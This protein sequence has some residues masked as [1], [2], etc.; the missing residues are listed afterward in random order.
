[1][2]IQPSGCHVQKLCVCYKNLHTSW[3]CFTVHI[4][5]HSIHTWRSASKSGLDI[6][7]NWHSA[8]QSK[9]YHYDLFRGDH[10]KAFITG[11]SYCIDQIQSFKNT[12]NIF[13]DIL[14]WLFNCWEFCCIDLLCG[15]FW[16][17]MIQM[18]KWLQVLLFYLL[19]N[20]QWKSVRIYIA[21]KSRKIIGA[22]MF[23]RMSLSWFNAA[24]CRV[25][26]SCHSLQGST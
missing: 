20:R 23:N 18:E 21:P 10:Y 8:F 25:N 19:L 3:V 6:C 4:E 22:H 15:S 11:E 1:M 13:F 24:I 12:F 17:N 5:L 14:Q 26:M 16:E 7:M 9:F 2:L